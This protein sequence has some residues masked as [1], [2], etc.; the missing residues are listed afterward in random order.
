MGDEV[1][2]AIEP[3]SEEGESRPRAQRE[4]QQHHCLLGGGDPTCGPFVAT[5]GL[6]FVGFFLP[7]LKPVFRMPVY[8]WKASA[9][10]LSPAS[11]RSETAQ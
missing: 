2:N 1:F 4:T 7:L 10:S 3:H 9:N 11:F 6:G 5:P 8:R